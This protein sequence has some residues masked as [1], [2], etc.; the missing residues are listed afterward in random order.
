[1]TMRLDFKGFCALSLCTLFGITG[2]AW[3]DQPSAQSKQQ[4]DALTRF[5]AQDEKPP[6]QVEKAEV[7]TTDAPVPPADK[8]LQGPKYMMLRYQDDFSY[9][10]G[11]EGSYKPDFFDPIKNIHLG[12]DLTLTIG[13]EVRGRLNSLTNT[14]FDSFPRTQDTNFEHREFIHFD[15]RYKK[16]FRVFFQGI[17]AMIE[18][19]DLPLLPVSENRFDFHQLFADLRV[20]G[21]DVPLTLRV[22][23][24]EILYG[25]QRM[26]SPLDWSNT[27]RRFDGVKLFWQ[28]EK[29]DADVFYLRPFAP[30]S[31]DLRPNET[32]NRKPDEYREEQHFYGLYTT[33][34]GIPNHGIDTYFLALRDT[35]DFANANGNTGDLS[36]YTLGSR[37]W[38]NTGDWDYDTELAGQW[39]KF[40]G[41]TIHAWSWAADTGYTF[42]DLPWSPRIGA[43]FDF[44]TGDQNP[45]DNTHD[46]FNQFFPL[47][48]AYLGYLD[49]VG[50]QNIVAQNVNLTF[51]PHKQLVA[52]IAWHTFWVDE[53]RDALYNAGGIPGRRA[54][55]GG[56]GH[57]V[58]HELDVTLNWTIDVHQSLVFGYSHFW[59][60]DFITD[61]G[62]SEDPDY[63]YLIYS[64]KF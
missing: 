53:V 40:A 7:T 37:F 30:V 25:K 14:R 39:G 50:R 45:K 33:Y 24:Q 41:D 55:G 43:G 5:A 4:D 63:F 28:S 17:N 9:L 8:P 16:L 12:D 22:G 10:D 56:A 48:H 21:E 38:G 42:K 51:K 62:P 11:E 3:A 61:T 15:L 13:G 64:F 54:P 26:M 2:A 18:D 27:R 29:F 20:L 47:G 23:R 60:S 6:A 46:T 58:G 31:I 35:G 36:L 19:N 52:N 1:M 57:E 59:D 49:L 44:A 34:K 32:Q